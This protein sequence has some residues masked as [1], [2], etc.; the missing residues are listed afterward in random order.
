MQVTLAEAEGKI[1]EQ[2]IEL[3]RLSTA[4]REYARRDRGSAEVEELQRQLKQ[5][6]EKGKQMWK[7]TCRQAADQEELL[8]AKD[9]EIE[10]LQG[11]L[12]REPV[13]S[14]MTHLMKRNGWEE[15]QYF[16]VQCPE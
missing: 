1:A 8:T 9:Q 3:E 4:V 5:E 11:R 7:L 6:K 13:G 10:E 16:P 12:R 15:L 2:V 14:G